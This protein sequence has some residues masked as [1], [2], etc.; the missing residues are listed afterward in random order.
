MGQL[1]I[2]DFAGWDT[3]TV[4]AFDRL[5]IAYNLAPRSKKF[6]R[7]LIK[8][9]SMY[10]ELKPRPFQV[11]YLGTL[12][13]LNEYRRARRVKAYLAKRDLVKT[14]DQDGGKRLV[15]TSRAHKI[16]YQDYPLARLRKEKWNGTWTLVSYDFPEKLK[17]SRGFIRR[18]LTHLGFGCAQ[19]SLYVCPL[20]LAEPLEEL[21][22]SET[23][24]DYVWVLT[25]Q[26]ILGTD[27]REVAAKAWSLASLS[28]LYENLI[29]VL[30]KIK[31]ERDQVLLHEWEKL[32]LSLDASDPYLPLE[33]LP[34][35]WPGE[36]C[37][38]E[39]TQLG[40]ARLLRSLFST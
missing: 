39:F 35:A 27:N 15:L 3:K 5:L 22:E 16:F 38:Q 6:I 7:S 30:P 36:K 17:V 11:D 28:R 1:K 25:A 29:E 8:F 20:P 31:Q 4:K 2:W 18:K 10:P 26:R 24:K 12:R 37:K 32:F 34:K 21:M 33:L 9:E 40:L 13:G 23:V 19:E 14:F